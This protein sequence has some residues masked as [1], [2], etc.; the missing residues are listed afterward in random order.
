LRGCALDRHTEAIA[1]GDRE[2]GSMATPKKS[3]TKGKT[4]SG[5]KAKSNAMGLKKK[6][7]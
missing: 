7:D 3:K 1:T 2:N 4:K 6:K 5:S